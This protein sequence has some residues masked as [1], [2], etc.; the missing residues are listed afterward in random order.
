MYV[1][2]A[3]TSVQKNVRR[4]S[5]NSPRTTSTGQ[6]CWLCWFLA[7][8]KC[9]AVAVIQ[10]VWRKGY[11]GS[12]FTTMVCCELSLFKGFCAHHSL[13]SSWVPLGFLSFR[14]VGKLHIGLIWIILVYLWWSHHELQSF[15]WLVHHLWR[16]QKKLM[17]VEM[18]R[19]RCS[20]DPR[21]QEPWHRKK[22]LEMLLR[23]RSI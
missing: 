17:M 10:L 7:W 2:N 8:P 13:F 19:A 6:H 3:C 18:E 15:R 11:S 5:P 20:R 23:W 21:G 12:T 4:S 22:H 16:A 9:H 1:H 14:L